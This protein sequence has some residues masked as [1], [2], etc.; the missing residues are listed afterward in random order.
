MKKFLLATTAA[1]ALNAGAAGAADMRM[2]VK[3]APAP[4]PVVAAVNWT[5]CY[6]AGGGGYGMYNQE[7]NEVTD[8]GG[9]PLVPNGRVDF[10]GRGWFGTVQGG[11][12]FQVGG[13]IVIG[14]FADYDFSNLRGDIHLPVLN[15]QGRE[16]LKNSWAAGGRIGWLPFPQLLVF[17]SG[18]YTEARFNQ[19][20]LF[21]QG[22]FPISLHIARHTYEGWFLGTG[23]EYALGFFPGLFWKTEYR[24]ADYGDD[25]VQ[26]R[27]ITGAP[28]GLAI[29]SEKRVH[30]VRSELVWRFNFGGGGPIVARN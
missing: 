3:A 9:F 19:V 14:A 20:D 27:D 1:V 5:G 13:N 25:R 21:N 10:G 16:K 22:G 29:N 7:V 8:P 26:I 4:A 11:C 2:P 18:G 23:Y 12:D 6:I 17:V 15:W 30:T 28:I 24:F